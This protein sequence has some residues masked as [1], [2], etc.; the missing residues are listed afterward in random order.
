[1]L[2]LISIIASIV[3]LVLT[4]FQTTQIARGK[5]NP[6]YKG[7]PEA[8]VA[9]F[10]KQVGYTLWLGLVFAVLDCLMI[11]I[12]TEPGEWIVDLVAG[13]LWLGVFAVSFYARQTL[14]KLPTPGERSGAGA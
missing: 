10:R 8:Y 7:T 5:I 4:P 14:A 11:L 12:S 13:V 9:A 3:I 1:M 2:E 6:K